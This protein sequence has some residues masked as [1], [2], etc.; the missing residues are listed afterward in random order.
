MVTVFGRMKSP[1][2]TL[3]AS[4]QVRNHIG[5][6]QT[7]QQGQFAMDVDKRYPVISLQQDDKQICEA[8]LDLSS[9]RGVLWVGDVICD[10]QTTL[11]VRN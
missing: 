4:A 2:G 3:L 8:E 10:P 11:A 7:D 5:R 1:D 9:A 6:T